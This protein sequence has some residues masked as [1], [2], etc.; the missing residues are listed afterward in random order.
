MKIFC[1]FLTVNISKVNFGLVI[2][3][4]KTFIWTTLKVI[5]SIFLFPLIFFLHSTIIDFQIVIFQPNIVLSYQTIHKWK[6]YLFSLRFEKFTLLTGFV[7]Q[8]HILYVSKYT[9]NKA[10][11]MVCLN[12]GF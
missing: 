9:I 3:I 8:G 10:Y 6:V 2:C 1:K 11:S 7:V 5:F 12:T 4:A